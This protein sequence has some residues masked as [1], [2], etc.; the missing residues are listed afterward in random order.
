MKKTAKHPPCE[1]AVRPGDFLEHVIRIRASQEVL[2]EMIFGELYHCFR[3]E[4]EKRWAE[5]DLSTQVRE[6]LGELED[7]LRILEAE[8]TAS[9]PASAEGSPR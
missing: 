6:R 3:D 4:N 5:S 2:T 1:N 7:G 8:K 9:Q